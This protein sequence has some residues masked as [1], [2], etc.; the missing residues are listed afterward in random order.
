[1]GTGGNQGTL[2]E[3]VIGLV[4]EHYVWRS[5]MNNCKSWWSNKLK[6][7]YGFIF[8][9]KE[10]HDKCISSERVDISQVPMHFMYQGPEY[11]TYYHITS[12]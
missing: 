6:M 7:I 1:M 4:L 11:G 5:T 12:W 3:V 9:G 2:I 8:E 10:S